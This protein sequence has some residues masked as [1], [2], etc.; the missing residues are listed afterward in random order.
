MGIKKILS[1]RKASALV[2]MALVLPIL[3][4]MLVGILEFGRI[5]MV[6]QVITN[7]AREAARVGVI[8]SDDTQ[9]LETAQSAAENYITAS[10]VALEK[11]TVAPQFTIVGTDDA[12]AVVVDYNYDSLL[13]GWIP[14]IDAT[15]TLRS[16][17]VMRRE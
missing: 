2:E 15:L 14:G 8:Y 3:T 16:T 5:L 9:A 10:G 13:A 6:K 4:L 11:A 1:A 17:S 12:L 7:A